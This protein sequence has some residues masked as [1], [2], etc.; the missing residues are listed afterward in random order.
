MLS[1]VV[2][3]HFAGIVGLIGLNVIREV[4]PDL[5]P[6]M[7]WGFPVVITTLVGSVAIVF[8]HIVKKN[9]LS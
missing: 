7:Y 6:M 5:H 9:K 4:R 8:L 1:W 3:A 2:T